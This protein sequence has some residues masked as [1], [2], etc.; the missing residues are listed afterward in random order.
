LLPKFVP[1][2][3]VPPRRPHYTFEVGDDIDLAAYRGVPPPKASRL[4]NERLLQ[5]FSARLGAS[6]GYNGDSRD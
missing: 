2:Y 6:G 3:R 1:W 5:H 4:L